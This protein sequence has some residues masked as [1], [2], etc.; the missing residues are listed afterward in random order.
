MNT[1]TI[2]G[3]S[4]T[5]NEVI[6][7]A[8]NPDIRVILSDPA[9]KAVSENR[10]LLESMLNEDKPIYGINTGFGDLA[11]VAI[12]KEKLSQLQVNLIRS[13]AV[14]VGKPLAENIVRAVLLLRANTLARG[15]SGAR[16]DLLE[17]LLDL[18]NCGVIPIIPEQGSLGASG[19]LAPLAHMALT[20]MG[21][22][23]AI[24]KGELM[25][26]SK[27][28]KLANLNPVSLKA[29]E[30]LALI[31]GTPV[32]SAIACF[33]LHFAEKL[34]KSASLISAMSIEALR[35]TEKAFDKRIH[36][37]RGQ[38]G[39]IE[40]AR[41]LRETLSG[42]QI[43]ESHRTC[44]KVQDAY[45]LRCTPQVLGAALD[46]FKH[47]A[48]V[49]ETEI[50]AV[51]DNPLV[52]EDGIFSGGNFHGEP[53]GLVMDYLSCALSEAGAIS[54]RRT[55]RLLTSSLSDLPPFLI[56]DSGVNSGLMI[57][58]YTAA[59][60]A[61]ENKG[62]CHPATVDSIPSSADQEDHVSMATTAARKTK[63]IT[64]NLASILAIE[65]LCSGQA[66]DILKPMKPSPTTNAAVKLLRTKVEFITE[67]R[68]FGPDIEAAR[69]IIESGELLE[70]TNSTSNFKWSYNL[71]GSC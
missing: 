3:K 37:L 56:K 41:H 44:E 9:K 48:E 61:S 28:L 58:Q 19:D 70:I 13:H 47:T 40:I 18:L 36:E 21:E 71:K 17:A 7:A 11:N 35:G 14:A 26:A 63:E 5:I 33:N 53:V 54:E 1:L 27:A 38:K 55:F 23:N 4:L 25:K 52:F 6:K 43:R 62:L 39:Q 49:I 60:L 24:Y 2:D 15:A 31:N 46:A 22:G 69:E 12:A 8:N 16:L 42:S 45:S 59:S 65:Y 30:G 10:K 64:T 34:L 68:W 32:M 67:D 57:T 20:L 51:T 50:N 66:I 29:K